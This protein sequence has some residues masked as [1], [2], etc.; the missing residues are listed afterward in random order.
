MDAPYSRVFM[1]AF[2]APGHMDLGIGGALYEWMRK[3][4]QETEPAI[5]LFFEQAVSENDAAAKSFLLKRGFENTRTHVRMKRDLSLA[6]PQLT[7][8]EG[9]SISSVSPKHAIDESLCDEIDNYRRHFGNS[10]DPGSGQ[11]NFVSLL[12]LKYRR[13]DPPSYYV[14]RIGNEV[15][16]LLSCYPDSRIDPCAAYIPVLSV[17]GVWRRKGIGTA[18]LL[19]ALKELPDSGAKTVELDV[20]IERSPELVHLCTKVGMLPVA[21]RGAIA[22]MT[23]FE[24]SAAVYD[25]D[26]MDRRRE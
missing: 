4:A 10:P 24:I 11:L 21:E 6:L 2:T 17:R 20:D 19:H 15:C 14:A 13:F 1:H 25:N 18:L 5:G 22:V 16:G 12:S 26:P 9:L 8:P 3:Q 23:K 7:G